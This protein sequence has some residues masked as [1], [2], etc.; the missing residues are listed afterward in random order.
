MVG[1]INWRRGRIANGQRG[2]GRLA[3]VRQR[4]ERLAIAVA[5]VASSALAATA[6]TQPPGAL[7]PEQTID[8]VA[9]VNGQQITRQ[10][11]AQQCVR[12]F[13]EG[14]LE[15]LINK[16]LILNECQRIGITITEQDVNDEL[17]RRADKFGMSVDRYI[18]VIQAERNISPDR[19][20]NDIIWIELALRRLAADQIEVTQQELA[21][22]M[23]F[24]F[25]PRVQVRAIALRTRAE[26]EEILAHLRQHPEDF[27]R[28][29][30]DRSV[31]P[32]SAAVRGLLPPIR[33]H[34]G[35]PQMEAAAFALAEGQISDVLDMEGQFIILRCEH[36]YPGVDLAPDQISLAEQHALEELREAKLGNAATELFK[37]LQANCQLQNVWNDPELR[38]QMPGV[39]ATVNGQPVTMRQLYEECIARFG[40]EVLEVEIN[41][42]ILTQRLAEQNLTVTQEEIQ[43]EIAR[44]ARDFGVVNADGSA[45]MEAWLAKVA[46]GNQDNIDVYVEDEVWPSVAMAKLVASS[47]QVTDE[48]MQKGFQSNYGERVECRA[49]VSSDHRTA[50]KIWEMA[51]ANPTEEYFG[52]LAHQYSVEPGSQANYGQVPPIQQHGGRPLLEAEAFRLKPGELS[53]IVNVGEHFI[54]LFCQG[55]T[56]PVVTDFDAVKDELY[57]HIHEK[58]LRIAMAEGFEQILKAAQIDNFLAGTSQPGSRAVDAVREQGGDAAPIGT[59]PPS[60]ASGAMAEPPTSRRR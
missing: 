40:L 42:A 25:G 6:Q 41:R 9:I 45:N 18:G 60:D 32:H 51:A 47:V 28:M 15:S 33:R 55:R 10:Q 50:Q 5:L 3:R 38:Q 49:I 13:G 54:I 22:R 11:L 52:Q 23:E 48:D 39:A 36:Q 7:P 16:H 53:S 58:K 4:V 17:K 12:R 29:A 31:D 19:L 2:P 37:R 8:V 35:E 27:E 34:M 43:E 20:K 30:K 59:P 1:W 14:V 21:E 26:A 44:A 56:T 24:E 46:G 57:K